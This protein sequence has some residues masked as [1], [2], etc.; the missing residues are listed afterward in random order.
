MRKFLMY[1]LVLSPLNLAAK[2]IQVPNTLAVVGDEKDS[3]IESSKLMSEFQVKDISKQKKIDNELKDSKWVTPVLGY[4]GTQPV[5]S[6]DN[7]FQLTYQELEGES[8]SAEFEIFITLKGKKTK[9]VPEVRNSNIAIS[10]DSNFIV[11]GADTIIETKKF[12]RFG[13]KP[14]DGNIGVIEKW[15]KDGNSFVVSTHEYPFDP[16]PTAKVEYWM[17]KLKKRK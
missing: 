7:S 12:K 5:K 10:P 8:D 17:I 13:F 3:P 2:T 11:L 15:A 1:I 9:L 16:P 14:G 4:G 6:P